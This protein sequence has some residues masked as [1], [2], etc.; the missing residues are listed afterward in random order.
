MLLIGLPVATLSVAV[1]VVRSSMERSHFALLRSKI[2]STMESR[3]RNRL[4]SPSSA[5]CCA[6][7]VFAA[8]LFSFPSLCRTGKRKDRE[9][10]R[11]LFCD[12]RKREYGTVST[13]DEQQDK[14]TMRCEGRK[15]NP[16]K[17]RGEGRG[18]NSYTCARLAGICT[19]NLRLTSSGKSFS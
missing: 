17:K 10:T 8:P 2:R 13:R 3:H 18:G 7:V 1:H 5:L 14:V 19:E 16:T 9:A 12:A 15:K 6:N 4:S 11:W